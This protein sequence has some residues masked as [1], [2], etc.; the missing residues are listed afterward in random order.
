MRSWLPS[1][2]PTAPVTQ[3]LSEE[4]WRIDNAEFA[5]QLDAAI[6]VTVS[7]PMLWANRI[8]DGRPQ[9]ADQL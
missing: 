1:D 8:L 6:P 9:H 4:V 2:N 5:G 3:W 7:D